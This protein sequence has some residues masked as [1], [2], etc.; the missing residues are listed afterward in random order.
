MNRDLRRLALPAYIVGLLALLASSAYYFVNRQFDVYLRVGLALAVIGVAAGVLLDPDRVRRVL[1]GRQARY[2]SNAL[3]ISLAFIG[4]LV[5]VNYL[6]YANPARTDLTEDQQ[7]S[8]APETLLQLSRLPAP[9][10]LKGFYTADMQPSAEEIRP[11]LEEYRLHSGGLLTYEF[12]NP[13]DNPAA[14]TQYGVAWDGSIVVVVGGASEVVRYP[15]EQG[16][17]SA[18][19]RLANPDPRAVYFLTGHG[20][21]DIE[22]ADDLGYGNLREAL[23]AKN[24]QVATLNLLVDPRIPE[25]ALAII[26]AGPM[27]PLRESEVELLRSFADSGGALVVLEEPTPA[28]RFGGQSD[29]L[30]A[31]LGQAWGVSLLDDLVVDRNSSMPL[32]GIEDEYGD[33][34][35]TNQLRDISSYFPSARSLM[36][37]EV[38]GVT[39]TQV[40][41]VAT[42]PNSWGE[43]DFD[44][45]SRNQIG[46]D[47][48]AD[49]AGPLTLGVAVEDRTTGARLVVFGDSDFAANMFF[50]ELANGD[51]LVNSID[52]AAGQESLI[53]LTPK[54][55][56]QRIVV[57]PSVQ[58]TGLIILTS[59]VLIPGTIVVMGVYVWWQRRRRA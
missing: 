47:E 28:T 45:L 8:L 44:A 25:D 27:E 18:L 16:L 1:T 37:T 49:H 33:H 20:E 29:P 11:L 17:T 31:Y 22:A 58:V 39:L 36:F 19:L 9:V 13:I 10:V 3:V 42:G 34:A 35:I 32:V 14:A 50:Y 2:G 38:P 40:G 4:I 48:R 54:P 51:L 59:V 55:T 57:P 41:L 26:I 23:V 6:A 5:V 56:T 52:W 43:T 24:Y 12:I 15:D 53:S 46:F 7:Y 30:A 21:H